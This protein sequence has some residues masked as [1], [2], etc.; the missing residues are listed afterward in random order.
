M[1]SEQSINFMVAYDLTFSHIIIVHSFFKD[2][3]HQ[4]FLRMIEENPI[5]SIHG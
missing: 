3:Y 5:I 4:W 2:L 1:H